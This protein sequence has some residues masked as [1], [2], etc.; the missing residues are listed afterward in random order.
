MYCSAELELE[1]C[2][3]SGHGVGCYQVP[4]RSSEQVSL[5]PISGNSVGSSDDGN[6]LL[7]DGVSTLTERLGRKR[8]LGP[9]SKDNN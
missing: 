5:L 3:S 8:F 6:L 2:L 4:Q 1:L 7:P 9:R